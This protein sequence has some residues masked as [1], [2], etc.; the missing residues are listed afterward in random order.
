MQ[1]RLH[2]FCLMGQQDTPR[3]APLPRGRC[4]LSRIVPSMLQTPY[5]G[6]PQCRKPFPALVPRYCTVPSSFNTVG[7]RREREREAQ[8]GSWDGCSP[9]TRTKRSIAPRIIEAN[10]ANPQKMPCTCTTYIEL[11][12]RSRRKRH[13]GRGASQVG[14][15][16]TDSGTPAPSE[17]S[18][19]PEAS[20][21]PEPPANREA[22][23][24]ENEQKSHSPPQPT[25]VPLIPHSA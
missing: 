8:S 22:E 1:I 10:P 21:P 14:G 24:A 2:G 23:K 12:V 9:T 13:R 15:R 25:R 18:E 17:P 5:S 7:R 16:Q 20:E 4:D 3:G 6:I 11:T 19:L